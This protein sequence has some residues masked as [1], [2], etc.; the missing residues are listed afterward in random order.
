MSHPEQQARIILEKFG[1][2]SLPINVEAIAK[3]LNVVVTRVEFPDDSI[4]GA[5][6]KKRTGKSTIF[7]NDKHK[8]VRRRFTIAHELGHFILH[9]HEGIHVDKTIFFRN[10]DSKEAVYRNEIDANKFAAEL[11]MPTHLVEKA[12]AK[13]SKGGIV[14]AGVDLLVELAEKFNVS[15]T[16]MAIRLQSVGIR[17]GL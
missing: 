7:V 5:L 12:A 9:D 3:K 10:N 15:T 11:L 2:D 4:S 16:A 14:D 6:E 1:L 8:E 17:I 13:Y